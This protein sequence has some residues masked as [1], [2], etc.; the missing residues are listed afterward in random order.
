MFG[1]VFLG[2]LV[3]PG[4]WS[5][6]ESLSFETASHQEMAERIAAAGPAVSAGVGMPSAAA[7]ADS[8]DVAASTTVA[9]T[10]EF[11]VAATWVEQ[12]ADRVVEPALPEPT[13]TVEALPGDTPLRLLTRAGVAPD[14][15][16]AA[17]RILRSVW[18][19]RGLRAGQKAAVLRQSDRLLSVRL[20]IAPGRDVVVARDDTGN[21][22][23]EDQERPTAWVAS[24]GTGT[25][26]TSLSDSASRA[27]IPMSVVAEMIRA[28]SY[29]VDFQREI[30]P[31]DTFSV[32]YERVHDEFGNATGVG[33]L[34]YGEMILNGMRLRLYRFTTPDGEIGFFNAIGENIRKP[35]LRTPIDGARLTSGFGM[36]F[37]PILGYSRMHRGVDFGAPIGTPVYAA[38]DG[39]VTR[40]GP[41]SGYGN[42]IEIEHNQE[43]ATAYGHLSG[44]AHGLHE[45][46]RVRQGDV[47]GYVGMTGLATGPHLHYEVHD[48]GI[49]IDPLS[50]KMPALT[51][52]AGSELK[53]FQNT[54][55]AIDRALLE[56]RRDLIA[57]V[58]EK[59]QAAA[60]P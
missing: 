17:I 35:L 45:G 20:P 30:H 23:A 3:L 2:G 42:Y 32:L 9:D 4:Q 15:A 6:L 60:A 27:G 10:A 19:P 36:R 18:D 55:S 8:A 57:S 48:H 7:T 41:A 44:F 1:V 56:M 26:W 47:I 46:A 34:L 39:I 38:G 59:G 31:G 12:S 49:Q 51:R 22:I 50:V 40:F 14:D 28:F 29:D 24:L 33:R 58:A 52:L 25:I 11:G 21:F 54:R 43:Y 37:H 16:Q 13:Q 5:S 53:A